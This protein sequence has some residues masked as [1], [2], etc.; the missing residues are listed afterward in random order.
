MSFKDFMEINPVLL[1]TLIGALGLKDVLWEFIKRCWQKNDEKD[2]DHKKLEEVEKKLDEM[3]EKFEQIIAKLERMEENDRQ[4][5]L[6][7]LSILETDLAEMQNRAIVK[8]KV[9]RTC[10]P[11]YLK[12]YN[13]YIKLAEETEGYDA[14]EEIKV[15]HKRILK[16]FDDG[17]VADNVEEW[18]K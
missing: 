1:A 3:N 18:Y 9:S 17:Y 12:N 8:G 16:L 4:G 13:Q 2:N 11:R 7:D 14:S 5:M 15:N 6:Y 10:M